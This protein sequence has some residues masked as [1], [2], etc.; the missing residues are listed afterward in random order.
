MDKLTAIKIKYEDGHYS[1]EIPVSALA[2]NVEWDETHTLVD[3]LG[4]VAV[5]DKGS[6]QDQLTQL[7]N[8]KVTNQ[9]MQNY[10]ANNMNTF[11]TA[12][13]NQNVKPVGSVVTID[14]TLTI[15]NSAADA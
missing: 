13:L 6:V 9:D 11:I 8:N 15:A 1:D 10:V 14:K 7:F 12:W 3:V 5:D 2:E 4:D